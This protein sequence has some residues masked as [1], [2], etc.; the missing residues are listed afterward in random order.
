MAARG[1]RKTSPIKRRVGA[2]LR[3]LR[4]SQ[5]L[6]L[7]ELARRA[8]T[9]ATE[10]ATIERGERAPNVVSLDHLARALGVPVVSFLAG[11]PKVMSN[12]P[13]RAE[14]IWFTVMEHLRGKDEDYLRAAY[15]LLLA[16][17]QASEDVASR[18]RRP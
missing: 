4:V 11:E 17:D 14:R 10:I 8:G 9:S 2:R 5:A 16:L 15:K 1:P 6:S 18:L 12:P 3:E 7:N 13:A